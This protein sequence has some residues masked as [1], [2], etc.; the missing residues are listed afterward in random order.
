M[1][2]IAIA[3]ALALAVAAGTAE[4]QTATAASGRAPPRT[5]AQ[6]ADICAVPET[7]P[8]YLPARYFGLGTIFGVSQY[9]GADRPIGGPRP[10]LFCVPEPPP[11]LTDAATRYVAWVRAHPE[12]TQEGVADSLVRFAAQT[13][14]CPPPVAAPTTRRR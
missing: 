2:R 13:Y 3:A 12:F 8:E 9:H 7:D 5:A 11:R 6:L 10:P 4:A 1:R 14:P